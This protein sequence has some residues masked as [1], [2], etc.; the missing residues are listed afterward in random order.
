MKVELFKDAYAIIDGIP[1]ERLSLETWQD[2]GEWLGTVGSKSTWERAIVQKPQDIECGTLACAA[3][4]LCL[5]PNMQKRGL[6]VG[7]HGQPTYVMFHQYDA[8]AAFFDIP[9]PEARGLFKVYTPDEREDGLD[10]VPIT[11][12]QRWL[13]RAR[14]LLAKYRAIDGW[15]RIAQVEFAY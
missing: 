1:D 12:R 10:G 15:Q 6:G 2:S 4:W 14:K 7:K 11:D 13:Q 8:L 3:V 9:E 5:H